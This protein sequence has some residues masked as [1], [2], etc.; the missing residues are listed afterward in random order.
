MLQ[1]GMF[2][3]DE[4]LDLSAGHKL[5]SFDIDEL[6]KSSIKKVKILPKEAIVKPVIKSL[7]TAGLAD[8]DWINNMGNKYIKRGLIEAAAEGDL[9]PEAST[10]PLSKWMQ[11]RK[12]NA[13]GKYY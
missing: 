3:G 9:A 10:S 13:E 6:K 4:Y 5:T 7:Y 11:G 12:L 1:P 8:E 2:L